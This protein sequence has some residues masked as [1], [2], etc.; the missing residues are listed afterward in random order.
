L[1][2]IV[3]TGPSRLGALGFLL[4]IEQIKTSWRGQLEITDA[5]QKLAQTGRNV[6]SRILKGGGWIPERKMTFWKLTAPC[7]RNLQSVIKGATST[8][9]AKWRMGSRLG[10]RD[11]WRSRPPS[12]RGLFAAALV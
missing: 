11:A 1:T 10:A 6:N 7:W 3:A 2:R 9:A 8:A 4:V 12:G 5:A